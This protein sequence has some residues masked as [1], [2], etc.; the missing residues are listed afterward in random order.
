MSLQEE[1]ERKEV[2]ILKQWPRKFSENNRF[3]TYARANILQLC[4]RVYHLQSYLLGYLCWN[5]L[6]KGYF[7]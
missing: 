7:F 2:D 4:P 1:E 5:S 3:Q 6:P